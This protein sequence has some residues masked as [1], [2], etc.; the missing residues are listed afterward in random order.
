MA[1][2]LADYGLRTMTPEQWHAHDLLILACRARW[3]DGF[4]RTLPIVRRSR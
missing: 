4:R 2:H 1:I 3:R